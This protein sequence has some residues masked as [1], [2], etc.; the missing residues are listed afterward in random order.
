MNDN[1]NDNNNPELQQL[2][3]FVIS[4]A[5]KEAAAVAKGRARAEK[6]RKRLEFH[7]ISRHKAKEKMSS[8][9]E[10]LDGFKIDVDNSGGGSGRNGIHWSSNAIC[11]GG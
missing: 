6:R 8:I 4:A 3:D 7:H 11:A 2:R 5:D 10:A 9:A 1:S